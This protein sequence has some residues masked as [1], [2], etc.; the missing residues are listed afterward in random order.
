MLK[1]AVAGLGLLAAA[2]SQTEA[3]ALAPNPE[4]VVKAAVSPCA[5]AWTSFREGYADDAPAAEQRTN[6]AALKPVCEDA[7]AKLKDVRAPVDTLRPCQQ[8]VADVAQ[9]GEDCGAGDRGSFGNNSGL[10]LEARL[11]CKMAT[12]TSAAA[13]HMAQRHY[14]RAAPNLPHQRRSHRPNPAP[15]GC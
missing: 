3:D 6:A 14:A 15:A 11:A 5:L 13:N 4:A 10:A 1:V 12:V 9:A 7:L 8:F 2:C